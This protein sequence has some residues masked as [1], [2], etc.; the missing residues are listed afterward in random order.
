[1]SKKGKLVASGRTP[2]V[3]GKPS[4]EQ[5]R[6]WVRKQIL[7][8]NFAGKNEALDARAASFVKA[9]REQF[10]SRMAGPMRR[11]AVNWGAYNTEVTWLEREDDIH[12]PEVKKACDSKVARIEEAVTGFDPVFECEGT[13]GQLSRHT[14]KVVGS[15]V[16]RKMEIAEWKD[17]VQPCARDGELC[18]VMAV[19]VDW[20]KHIDLVVDRE[21]EIQFP[22]K[23]DPYWTWKRFMRRATTRNGPRL[24]QVDP[25]WFIYDLEAKRAEDCAYIGDEST[26]F[27]HDILADAERG[28]FSKKAC[29]KLVDQQRNASLNY[30]SDGTST[31]SFPDQLRRLRSIAQGPEYARDVHGDSGAQ[32]VRMIEMWAYFDFRDGE[33]GVTDPRGIVLKGV[34]KVVITMAN[35]V[36]IRFQLNPFDRKFVPYAFSLVNRN[37]HEM[38]APAPFDSVVQMSA[39]YDRLAS[40]IMRWM[41]LA[42]SP[43]LI[44]QDATNSDLPETLQDVEPGTIMKHAGQWNFIKVPDVTSSIGYMHSYFR[45]ELEE[46]SG[47]LRVF[48]SPQGTATETERKVQEQQRMVRSS[49]RASGNL[50]R[51]VAMIIKSMEAQF[52]TGPDQFAVAGKD[53]KL[54]GRWATVT[55]DMLHEEV[56]FRFLG[57]TDLHTFGN[58]LQGMAQWMN[59]WGPM[60][61]TMPRVDKEALCRLDFELS[62][63]RSQ[64]D[65]IFPKQESPWELWTQEEENEILLSGLD[66]EVNEADDDEAHLEALVPLLKDDDVPKYV[67]VK[68]MDHA[69]MHMQQMQRKEMEQRQMQQ[70][71]K[72][73]QSLM[74]M[75]GGVPGRDRPPVEGGMQAQ[76]KDVT[77]GPPQQRTQP[78][79]GRE[80]SGLAQTQVMQ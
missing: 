2:V 3:K 69:K 68:A 42:V 65:V 41:D 29:E 37:G 75:Q 30:S 8:E 39:H 48:E 57:L 26:P 70:K 52:S 18:N 53:S 24:T 80:G 50:W 10:R 16:Y 63:G 47:A 79:T 28:L 54:I 4:E 36:V 32:R 21:D 76:P 9:R 20:E 19:K 13:K 34:H 77:P 25:F 72:Q 64:L 51:Q 11:W 6:A 38:V 14:A 46:T 15:Y 66:V 59:R 67:K 61:P 12:I 60:L 17:L 71:A 35:D 49:I 56:D 1:M 40:N 43:L 62:V 55:P 27:L 7:Y 45:R 44:A 31:S 58:R 74:E 73:N 23:G 5:E 78:R 33:D 22:E